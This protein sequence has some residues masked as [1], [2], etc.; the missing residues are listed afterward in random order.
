MGVRSPSHKNIHDL[1]DHLFPNSNKVELSY[2]TGTTRKS[3]MRLGP[4]FESTL[5]LN[6]SSFQCS[7]CEADIKKGTMYYK[8][9]K[10]YEENTS[11]S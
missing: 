8:I 5:P 4:N 9:S 1:I 11:N 3:W 10:L 6:G 2:E 7:Q